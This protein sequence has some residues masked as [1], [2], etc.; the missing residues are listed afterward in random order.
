MQ[1]NRKESE[2]LNMKGIKQ[3]RMI[4]TCN[5]DA[6]AIAYVIA[7]I[8]NK[9]LATLKFA[10]RCKTTARNPQQQQVQPK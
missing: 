6:A 8:K 10:P 4:I 1:R 3:V 9:L 2:T 5:A 7:L